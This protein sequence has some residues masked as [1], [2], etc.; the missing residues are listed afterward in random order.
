M[1]WPERGEDFTIMQAVLSLDMWILFVSVTCGIGAALTAIDNL[2][3]IGESLGYSGASI[4]TCVSL[5][6]IWNFLGRVMAGFGSEYL[7]SRFR[8]PRTLALTAI[9]AVACVGHILVAFPAPG[10]LYVASVIVGLCF[11]AQW[12]LLYAIVSELFGL[13]YYATLYNVGGVASPLGSYLLNV[14]VAGYLYDREALRQSLTAAEAASTSITCMGSACF[15]LTFIIMTIVS[16]GGSLISLLLVTR[17]RRFYA[18]DIYARFSTP[19]AAA[20]PFPAISHTAAEQQPKGEAAAAK[21]YGS[22]DDHTA[23]DHKFD[24]PAAPASTAGG[25]ACV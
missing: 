3:Q 4:S 25:P 2:G 24:A 10:T 7:L 5:I 12:P 21:T 8:F 22:V 9:M 18:Q 11:G 23:D 1:Q 13:K 17:T 20:A 14:K 19:S 16:G 15:R 6:S